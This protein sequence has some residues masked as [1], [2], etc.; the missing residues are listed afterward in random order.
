MARRRHLRLGDGQRATGRD[1]ELQADQIE[2]GHQFGDA[3]LDLQSGIHL[4]KEELLAI[5]Q[6]LHRADALIPDRRGG[7]HGRLPHAG[8][9]G[10]VDQDRRRFLN[11]L[12]MTA[13][14]RTFPVVEMQDGS[15]LVADDLHLDV[16]GRPEVSLEEDLVGTEGGRRLSPGRGDCLPEVSGASTRRMPRPPP[17]AE[18]LTRSG[19][20]NRGGPGQDLVV[21]IP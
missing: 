11:D 20:A 7:R 2:P 6:K 13:L 19:K 16:T 14:H 12:L 10:R 4:Q 8:P 5:D 17:P 21:G 9:G 18:A 3:V 15:M 1:R